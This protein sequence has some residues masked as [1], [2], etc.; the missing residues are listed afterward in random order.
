MH[1]PFFAWVDWKVCVSQPL[2]SWLSNQQA[3]LG[4]TYLAFRAAY[5]PIWLF[6]G[7]EKGNPQEAAMFTFPQY[8]INVYSSLAVLLKVGLEKDISSFFFGSDALG[9]FA[10]TAGYMGYAVGLVANLNAALKGYFVEAKSK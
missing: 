10:L 4:A 5:A 2:F 1:L 6:F 3:K 9:V 8:S 7:G